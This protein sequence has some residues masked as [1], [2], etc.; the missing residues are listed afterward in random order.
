MRP[1]TRDLPARRESAETTDSK[2]SK[3]RPDRKVASV[4]LEWLA[5]AVLSESKATRAL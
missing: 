5:T 4:R 3:E 1:D 2:V